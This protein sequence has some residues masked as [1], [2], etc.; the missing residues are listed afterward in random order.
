MPLFP[1]HGW[2]PQLAEHGTVASAAIFL[3]GL[4]LGI[5]SVIRYILPLV[6]GVAEQWEVFVLALSLL[7]IF[8]GA[9]QALL[10]INIR[11]LLA[12]AV[13]SHNGMLVIGIFSFNEYGLE[14]SLL[15]S[16]VYGLATAGALFSVGLIYERTRTAFI[17]RLGGL[18]DSNNTLALLFMV[19][20]LSTMVMPGTPGFDAAHVLIEGIIEEDG[21]LIA[22]AILSGNLLAA[23]FLLRSFQLVFI[24]TAK[25]YR[26]PYSSSHH[27][28]IIERFIAIIICSLLI[29]SGFYT[30]PWLN[31]I[32]QE[33][34]AIR[35]LYPVH[36]DLNQ[37]PQSISVH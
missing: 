26:Q 28:V 36:S 29:G 22:I 33:M 13:I 14:G 10:Q 23:A 17:P 27:P 2:L 18:F 4:K 6:P 12:F 15:L 3:V 20:A 1:F 31:Y 8:Y 9:G 34:T 19:S 30:T 7:S 35:Q 16:I 32:D 25:R 24:S 5:Y 21:W 11:K 37:T